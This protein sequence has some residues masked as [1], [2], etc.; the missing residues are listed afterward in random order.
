MQPCL[1]PLGASNA[2]SLCPAQGSFRNGNYPEWVNSRL[3]T[4]SAELQAEKSAGSLG[5]LR[6][7]ALG[8]AI[9]HQCCASVSILK[10]QC[11]CMSCR[12]LSGVSQLWEGEGGLSVLSHCKALQANLGWCLAHLCPGLQQSLSCQTPG[13]KVCV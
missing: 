11:C 1:T 3:T 2:D 7:T 13:V 5:T 10:L 4:S 8:I 12:V 9:T 6:H